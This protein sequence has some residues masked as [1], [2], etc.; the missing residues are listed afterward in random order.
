[1]RLQKGPYLCASAPKV[2]G[3]R[4]R[5]WRRSGINGRVKLKFAQRSALH[6][7]PR[8]PSR[9][10]LDSYECARPLN[11]RSGASVNTEGGTTGRDAKKIRLSAFLK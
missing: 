10:P 11:E 3:G 6:D 7:F 9:F 8:V 5:Q 1:M 2:S 4:R